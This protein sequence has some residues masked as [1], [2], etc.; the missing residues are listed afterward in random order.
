MR[1]FRLSGIIL[2]TVLVVC[3]LTTNAVATYT[4]EK[5]F[6]LR[7]GNSIQQTRDGGYIV[8]GTNLGVYLVKTDASGNQ[9]WEKIFVIGYYQVEFPIIFEAEILVFSPSLVL[10]CFFEGSDRRPWAAN[11]G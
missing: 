5:T 11:Q 3:F 8:A 9:V 7:I 6:N 4:W 1:L 10:L 2:T